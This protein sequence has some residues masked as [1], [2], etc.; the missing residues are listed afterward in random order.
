MKR[1]IIAILLCF[2][3]VACFSMRRCHIPS[4]EALNHPTIPLCSIREG[5]RLDSTLDSILQVEQDVDV[6]LLLNEPN[7]NPDMEIFVTKPQCIPSRLIFDAMFVGYC[8]YHERNCYLYYSTELSILNSV[9]R[10]RILPLIEIGR[11]IY[12]DSI[13]YYQM[14]IDS[15]IS[16]TYYFSI[17]SADD[18]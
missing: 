8:I 14:K 18:N 16:N 9:D 10:K 7:V 12:I 1:L 2:C 3:F 6:H 17:D 11:T 15:C 13:P 5:T 4:V